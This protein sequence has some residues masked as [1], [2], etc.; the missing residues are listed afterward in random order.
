[1][2]GIGLALHGLALDL[3]AP[4]MNGPDYRGALS[5]RMTFKAPSTAA[6]PKVSY[7]FIASWS[8]KRWVTSFFRVDLRPL[9]AE[10]PSADESSADTVTVISARFRVAAAGKCRLVDGS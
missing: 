4:P 2:V 6:F 9:F 7:A 5:V 3:V 1:L 10:C 8:A